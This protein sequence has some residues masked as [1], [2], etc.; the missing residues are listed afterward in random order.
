MLLVTSAASPCLS[1]VAEKPLRAALTKPSVVPGVGGDASEGLGAEF[2]VGI[3]DIVAL[4]KMG[5][6]GWKGKLVVGWATGKSVLD[7]LEIVDRWGERKVITA[8][9]G[10]DELFNRLIAMGGQKWECL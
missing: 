3:A 4:R 8:V 6:F 2:T 10:R 9:K 5:G 1:F 7:G